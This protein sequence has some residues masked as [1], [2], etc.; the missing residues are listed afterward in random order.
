MAQAK[1]DSILKD[2]TTPL[3]YFDKISFSLG[4]GLFIPQGELK[5][6]FGAAPVIEFN[7]NFPIKKNK[8]I[9]FVGQ[10]IIPNQVEDFTYIRNID[11]IQVKSTMMVN[12]FVKFKKTL[13]SFRNSTLKAYVGVGLSSI[14]TN[15]RN[16]FYSGGERES[17]YESVSTLLL[18][19]GINY[20]FNMKSNTKLTIGINYQYAPY[21]V[22]GALR[23]DI[24]SSGIVPK[25]LFTF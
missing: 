20:I 21:K 1:K 25:L 15:A 22:E 8:S 24:G 13:K 12:L 14:T 2:N 7:L 11:T 4:S 5:T 18:A 10:I 23:Q 6:Y 17:K 19:P 16:P 9:D 3:N